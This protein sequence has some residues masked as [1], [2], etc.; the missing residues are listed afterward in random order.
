MSEH[1]T[2]VLQINQK[3]FEN[4]VLGADQPVVVDFWA[5]WC[6]PCR[7]IA[8]ILEKLAGEYGERIQV[9]KINTDENQELAMQH[10]VRGIPTLLFFRDGQEVGRVVGMAPESQ[11]KQRIEIALMLQ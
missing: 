10:N 11:I 6:S 1:T 5:P 7:M 2:S 3:E 9:I 4:T 8:P